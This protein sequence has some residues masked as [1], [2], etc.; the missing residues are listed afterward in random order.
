MIVTR[1]RQG[2]RAKINLIRD[3]AKTMTFT[4]ALA[5]SGIART[6]LLQLLKAHLITFQSAS[7]A[8]SNRETG[9]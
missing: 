6:R 8:A 9:L 7:S 1:P 4:E 3:M 5:V 2:S